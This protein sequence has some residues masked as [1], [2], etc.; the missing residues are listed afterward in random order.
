VAPRSLQT[1]PPLRHGF[2]HYNLDIEPV[3]VELAAPL[4]RARDS[5]DELW[6][7]EGKARLGLAAPVR[8]LLKRLQ[9]Q[10]MER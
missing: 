10:E 6:Y 4:P 7:Q 5:A 8:K 3:L 2:S 9:G 1:W